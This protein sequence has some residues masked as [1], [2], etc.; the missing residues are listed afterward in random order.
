MAE[1][2]FRHLV[3]EMGRDSEF[4]IR[5]A[6]VAALETDTAAEQAIQVMGSRGIKAIEEHQATPIN[7]EL[8]EYADLILTM[9]RNHKERLLNIYPEAKTKIYTLK[10]Y[11]ILEN[12]KQDTTFNYDIDDPYGQPVEVYQQCAAELE[13]YLKRL[14]TKI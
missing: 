2:L 11:T 9:T 4:F 3:E 8:I 13:I 7:S 10:E 14:L 6:G 1:Y 12:E 5:S